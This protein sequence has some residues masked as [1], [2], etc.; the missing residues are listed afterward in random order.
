M[1]LGLWERQG[2]EAASPTIDCAREACAALRSYARTF[3]IGWPYVHVMLGWRD[4][5][6]GKPWAARRHWNSAQTLSARLDMPY[7]LARAHFEAGRHLKDSASKQHL[8]QAQ[9]MFAQLGT[10]FDARRAEAYLNT[11]S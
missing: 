11:L 6:D 3:P 7:A 8:Q 2:Q 1:Y 4:W 5:L 9:E 10:A